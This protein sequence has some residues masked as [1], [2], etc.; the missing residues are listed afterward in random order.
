MGDQMIMGFLGIAATILGVGGPLW[1]YLVS[2]GKKQALAEQRDKKIDDL[3]KFA[4]L[5]DERHSHPEEH[6]IGTANITKLAEEVTTLANEVRKSLDANTVAITSLARVQ[7]NTNKIMLA[8]A[9][10]S[11]SH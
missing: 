2:K 11:A 6:G 5:N 1:G 8:M 7:N 3:L 9:K 4:K 10:R